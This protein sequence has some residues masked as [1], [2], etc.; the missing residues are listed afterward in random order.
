MCHDC[1]PRT[2]ID[3]FKVALMYNSKTAHTLEAVVEII[4]GS[5]ITEV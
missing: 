5:K 3:N 1:M 2:Q 4:L